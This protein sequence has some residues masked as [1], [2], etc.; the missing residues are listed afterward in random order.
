MANKRLV[1][2]YQDCPMCG[3]RE[4]WGEKQLATAKANNAEIEK[5]S[6]VSEE[7]RRYC[8]EI[9]EAGKAT[10]PFF[11]DGDGHFGATVDELLAEI[12]GVSVEKVEKKQKKE[13]RSRKKKAEGGE[14]GNV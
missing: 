14:N 1:L 12:E 3:S 4:N 7:G 11:T 2:V 9:I 13:R 6:F 8:R 10:M 5:M